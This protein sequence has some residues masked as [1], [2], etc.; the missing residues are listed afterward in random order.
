MGIEEQIFLVVI[1]VLL[2][3]VVSPII[4]MIMTFKLRTEQKRQAAILERLMAG[5]ETPAPPPKP[6]VPVPV[7]VTI[8]TPPP[9]PAPLARTI[10]VSP[11]PVIPKPLPRPVE[12]PPPPAVPNELQVKAVEVMKKIWNWIVIGDEFRRPGTSWEFAVATNWLLRAGIVVVVV[13]VGFFLKYSIEH[14]MLG[15]Q[16]RVALSVLA[17]VGMLV[18][19]VKMIGKPYQLVGQGLMGGGL[20][21]LYFSMFAACNFYHLIGALAA[22]G[23]MALVTLV[24]GTLAVRLNSLLV[25]VLG[26]LGGYGTPI[27]LSTGSKNFPGLFGYMLLLGIGILGIARRRH[28]P[29]LNYLGLVLTYGLATAA[30]ASQYVATDFLDVLPFLI[31]FFILYAAVMIL[32]NLV[33]GE[34]AGLLELLGIIANAL[35]FF[36]LTHR[37]I[38]AGYA[39]IYA[40]IPALALAVFFIVATRVFLAGKRKD[41]GLLYTFL[42]LA[43]LF[44]AMTPPL[45]LSRQWIT[46]SWALQGVVMLWLAGKIDSRFL[47]L[48]GCAACLLSVGRLAFWD[49]HRQFSMWLPPDT[50]WVAYLK[51]FGERLLSIGVPIASLGAAWKFLR[52]PPA[53]GPLVVAPENDL[54]SNRWQGAAGGLVAVLACSVLFVYAHVELYHS[55]RFFWPALSVPSMTLAWFALGLFLLAVARQE[56][57]KWVVRVLACLAIGLVIKVLIV[58]MDGWHLNSNDWFYSGDYLPGLALIRFGD[59]GLCI[60]LFSM[61]Y[62]QTRGNEPGRRVGLAVG[63]AA[64]VLLFVY[65]SL[66]MNT[67]L[68]RFVPGL[69][70]GGITLLWAAY[71]L[72]LL[73]FGLGKS[74]KGLRYA[75]LLGFVV[76]V[77][78]I[79]F[80]DLAH[81]DA[82][83]KIVAFIVLGVMLLGAA[84]V[85][86][87]YRQRFQ[88]PTEGDPS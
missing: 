28:W 60:G 40:A 35:M 71:A 61:I 38:T 73:L 69:R 86:L 59:F 12:P 8:T 34:K 46:T 62:F 77:L 13:G 44:T 21:I 18:G 54:A 5:R 64:L 66:E 48:L 41:R 47:R 82:L 53:S 87:K 65:L 33:H 11:P 83:Y 81:L 88:S 17:G 19:G 84:F 2:A 85:Y 24:A 32:H 76:V 25:A 1:P 6:V 3:L 7:P 70:A 20:A 22:F 42:A 15:P 72:T 31:S 51:I 58:D 57:A 49:L 45:A 75:G 29:L 78:K 37:V 23:L 55:C 9:Q 67:A 43:A 63:I 36:G 80:S 26:I 27:M 50:T 68:G 14:G 74:V 56:A 16:A 4:S 79:F 30:I 52:R 10:P 39:E